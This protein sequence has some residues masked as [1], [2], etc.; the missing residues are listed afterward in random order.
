MVSG[1]LSLMIRDFFCLHGLISREVFL[2]SRLSAVLSLSVRSLSASLP[3][4]E[5]S[6]SLSFRLLPHVVSNIHICLFPEFS[7][8]VS[9]PDIFHVYSLSFALR[10]R[11]FPSFLPS[12]FHSRIFFQFSL[13]YLAFHPY[14]PCPRH[15]QFPSIS[16]VLSYSSFPLESILTICLA[17][18]HFA[19]LSPAPR[20]HFHLFPWFFV[21]EAGQSLGSS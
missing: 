21:S 5:L 4:L 12:V 15:P 10:F 14:S 16:T 20:V 13:I 18:V 11:P 19:D 3:A 17:F 7:S 2:L 6:L 9:F 1:N 8:V